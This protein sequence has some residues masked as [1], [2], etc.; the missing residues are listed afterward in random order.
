MANEHTGWDRF[1]NYVGLTWDT[2]Y[3]AGLGNPTEAESKAIMDLGYWGQE[4]TR[5]TIGGIKDGKAFADIEKKTFVL[6]ILAPDGTHTHRHRSKAKLLEDAKRYGPP[7]YPRGNSSWGD[8][9]GYRYELEGATIEEVFGK[10]EPVPAAAPRPVDAEP[11]FEKLWEQH[12]D[13]KTEQDPF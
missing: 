8:D 5:K 13:S 9:D 10:P 1:K 7:S 12:L 11:D 3:E 6:R 4:I 2:V